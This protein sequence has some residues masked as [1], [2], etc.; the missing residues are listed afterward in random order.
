MWEIA[1]ENTPPARNDQIASGV[2]GSF[3]GESLFRMASLVLEHN[4]GLPQ[5]WHEA[6]AAAISPATG[7]NRLAFGKRFKTVFPS[8]DPEH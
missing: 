4:N 2:A 1:G 6:A 5:A 7:F 3:L 8:H